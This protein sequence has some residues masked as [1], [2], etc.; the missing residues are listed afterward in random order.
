MT[1]DQM[2]RKEITKRGRPQR[3]KVMIAV[4]GL[5][6][7]LLV[8]TSIF[9]TRVALDYRA[10]IEA[11]QTSAQE[12]YQA[13]EE[14]AELAADAADAAA[15]SAAAAEVAVDLAEAKEQA[16]EAAAAAAAAEAAAAAAEEPVGSGPIKC[17]AGSSANSGDG[18]NDTSCFPDICFHITLPDPGHPECEVAFKP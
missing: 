18:P 12:Y 13:A 9:G 14:Q 17:P 4:S 5:G 8:A 11:M 6:V 1:A 15:E 2:I 3:R 7:A 10:D 16:A